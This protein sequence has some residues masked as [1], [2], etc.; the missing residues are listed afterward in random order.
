[1]R[2]S[3]AI[4]IKLNPI[5]EVIVSFF[6]AIIARSAKVKKFTKTYKIKP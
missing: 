1:L 3:E 6:G 2:F 5:A 4:G